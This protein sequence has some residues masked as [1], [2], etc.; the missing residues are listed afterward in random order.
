MPVLLLARGEEE[1]RDLLR[2]A[3]EAR[4]GARPPAFDSL[5][6]DFEGRVHARLGPI[7]TWVPLDVTSQFI[8]PTSMRWDFT[9][10]PAGVP[11]RRG[12]ESYD[13]T[14][15]RTMSGGKPVINED[16]DAVVSLQKR[17]WAIAA[18][19]LTPLGDSFVELGTDGP[20]VL[21]ARNTN[22]DA[23]V[24]IRISTETYQILEVFVPCMN[25]DAGKEQTFILRPGTELISLDELL[26]PTKISAFW[27]EDPWFEVEPVSAENDPDIPASV[28]SLG[29]EPATS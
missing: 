4:Y 1:A 12:V 13:G 10:K 27:D 29:T 19:L 6:I 15:L 8:L 17:L 18:L 3:I 25:A 20:D 9:A 23:T 22:L 14:A 5:R 7:K 16:P 11:V 21:T 24:S 26:L 28:F 2:K